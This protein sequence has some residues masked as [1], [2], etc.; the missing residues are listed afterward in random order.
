MASETKGV[1]T[2]DKSKP[3]LPHSSLA[4]DGWS[5]EDEATATCFCG[6]VQ[7]SF[8]INYGKGLVK[9]F[10]CNCVDCRKITASMFASNF[11]VEDKHLKHIRGQELLK[12]FGQKETI[13]SGKMMTN[14]FCSNC[15]TLMY[16]VGERFPGVSLLR[17]GTVDDYSLHETKLKP[18]EEHFV[19]DRVAWFSGVKDVEK[20]FPAQG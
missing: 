2:A 1:S 16:R 4:T 8:P 11:T 12:T 6:K 9:T 3:Y 18:L 10:V 14:Y 7:L 5:T 20:T 17:I 19:K 15:G 13:A